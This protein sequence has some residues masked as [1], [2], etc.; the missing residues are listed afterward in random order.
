MDVIVG[1]FVFVYGL[2]FGSFFNVCIYRI[3]A[4]LSI[5][6]PGSRCGACEHPLGWMDLL[7]IASYVAL[8]AKCR[9][10]GAAI[11]MR[12]P[13]VE[14]LT[15]FLFIAL[16]MKFGLTVIF[17][18]SVILTS[19]LIILSFIDWDHKI[20]PDRLNLGIG[21]LGL[22]SLFIQPEITWLQ[23]LLGFL[24][25]GG[26]LFLIAIVTGAMGGGDIKLMAATGLYLGLPQ[27]I[28]ALYFGF[29]IGGVVSVM[30]LL[31]KIKGRK[32]AIAF[33]PYLALGILFS[34]IYGKQIVDYYM[35]LL[36]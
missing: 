29:I 24:V 15:G 12:Y 11:A 19:L 18:K 27:T 7:P 36:N 30:L 34:V 20:I 32:D 6:K 2:L 8:K 3:P 13:L 10:C 16:Y 1:A 25:G 28:I 22:L 21:I 17:L 31:L 33:G 23:S 14:L 35:M 5:I 26:F 9:Y 4:G